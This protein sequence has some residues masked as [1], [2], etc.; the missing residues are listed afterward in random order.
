MAQRQYALV[1][2]ALLKWA[3]ESARFELD[4]AA[5]KVGVPAQR[6]DAWERGELRPTMNQLRKLANTYK[7]PIAVFYLPEPPTEFQALRDFRTLPNSETAGADQSPELAYEV[8][9]VQSR[10]DYA[11]ELLR[12]AFGPLHP[13]ELR[14]S[15]DE[16]PEQVGDRLRAFLGVSD[17]DQFSWSPGYDSLNNWRSRIEA[18]GALAFQFAN[19]DLSVARGFS[20]FAE[21]LPAVAANSKDSTTGRTFTLLHEVTHLALRHGGICDLEER[22]SPIE[23]AG[24]EVFCNAVAAAALVPLKTLA[25]QRHVARH[26]SGPVWSDS[27]LESLGRTYGASPEAILRRL[28]ALGETSRAFYQMKRRDFF[29]RYSQRDPREVKVPQHRLALS[30]NG[31]LFTQIVLE[32]FSQGTITGAD[33]S[34]FLDLRLKHLR[35]LQDELAARVS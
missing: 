23:E 33:V 17:S 29:N 21:I 5:K 9:R 26:R 18:S 19:V 10:R 34:E 28:L 3:R 22:R 32:S 11:A 31:P 20:A 27:E 1:D 4:S 12:E 35:N 30:R 6:L 14:A 8:H 13:F 16:D 7:R 25:Q 24:I 15:T 2:G